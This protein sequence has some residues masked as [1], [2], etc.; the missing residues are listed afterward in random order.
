[1]LFIHQ[2][3]DIAIGL[4]MAA[5]AI[6]GIFNG[7]RQRPATDSYRTTLL[8]AEGLF[9]VQS[10]VGME[11]LGSGKMPADPLHYLYGFFGIAVLPSITGWVGRGRKRESLW[12]GLAALFL[13]GV[14]FRAWA[15]GGN[16]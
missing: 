2:R 4:F 9:V 13:V 1:V 7:V 16:A 6:W 3:L 12:L 11:L 8:I 14:A 5:C 15:T 10:L